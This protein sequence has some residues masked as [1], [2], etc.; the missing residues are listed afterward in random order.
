MSAPLKTANSEGGLYELLARGNKDVF[1]YQDV[2]DSKFIFD[3]GYEAQAPYSFEIR[4]DPPSTSCEF[5]RTVEFPINIIGDVMRNPTLLIQLPSWLPPQQQQTNNTS[6]ITDLSGYSYGYVNG[7]AYFLFERIQLFQDTILLQEFSGDSLWAIG[8]TEG[9]Y[10]NGW[11]TTK[12]RGEHNGSSLS[13]QHNTTPGLL[14]LELPLIGCQGTNDSGF[15]QRAINTHIYK[16]R[17]KLRK[18]EDLVESSQPLSQCEKPI[19]WGRTFKQTLT[20]N[21]M[22]TN[23]PTL[24][25]EQIP[26]LLLTLES[27]QIYTT[28]EIQEDLQKQKLQ[29]PF[30]RVTENVFSQNRADYISVLAGGTSTINRRLDGRHP[31]GRILFYFRSV[32]DI[33]ANRW[34][35]IGA[36]EGEESYYKSISLTIAGQARELPRTPF[37]WR[38]IANFAKEDLDTG[39]QMNTMNWTLGSVAPLRFPQSSLETPTG[40]VN[41]TT[42]DRANLYIDLA[43]PQTTTPATQLY[44]IVEGWAVFQTDK[45]R[46]ELYN[47][48]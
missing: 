16:L 40:T 33:N 1:F 38:D 23:F 46:A 15:P 32:D 19:P 5:G 4:K 25:R 7:I 29:V 41:F 21:G 8:K 22:P 43:N 31:S 28:K 47:Q 44:V 27:Q 11:V 24:A 34:W 37:V 39:I 9:T 17:I 26:P 42:A 10:G 20:K 18:L 35:K 48:N 30:R 14:R 12:L 6:L 45:G 36:G 13:I 3:N 2:P